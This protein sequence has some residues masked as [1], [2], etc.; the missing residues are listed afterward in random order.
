MRITKIEIFS[1]SLPLK[2]PFRIAIGVTVNSRSLFI[3]IHTDAGFYGIGEANLLTPVV[4]ETPETALAAAAFLCKLL[5]GADPLDAEGLADKL[6]KAMPTQATTRSAFDM[7]LW[8]IL[9]KAA[10]MPLYAVLG[11]QRRTIVTDNTVGLE[12]PVVMSG[13]ASDFAARGFTAIKVKLGTDLATDVE[14]VRLIR[15]IRDTET[16]IH[17]QS[18]KTR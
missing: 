8:D 18:Y 12:T 16:S 6:R 2:V 14:R 4:G 15:G 11:G 5:I 9:G 1:A 17:L 13:R 3:R 10:N 7:A